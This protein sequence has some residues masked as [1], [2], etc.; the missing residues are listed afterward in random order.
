M[1]F[2]KQRKKVTM[3]RRKLHDEAEEKGIDVAEVL[4]RCTAA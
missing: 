3:L 1:P 2:V 4:H